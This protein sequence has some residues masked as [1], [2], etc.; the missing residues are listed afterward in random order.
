MGTCDWL[1]NAVAQHCQISS[2]DIL[3]SWA[4]WLS[5]PEL[6]SAKRVARLGKTV[7]RRTETSSSGTLCRRNVVRLDLGTSISK[8]WGQ[9]ISTSRA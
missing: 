4:S 2:I 7:D 6:S 1:G 9:E 5:G 8:R 3:L